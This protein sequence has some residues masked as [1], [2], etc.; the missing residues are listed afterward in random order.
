MCTCKKKKK[1]TTSAKCLYLIKSWLHGDGKHQ[2]L[3]D[4]WSPEPKIEQ[5][6]L[7]HAFRIHFLKHLLKVLGFITGT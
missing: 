2:H 6:N 1:K 5:Y 3:V 4:S 7:F